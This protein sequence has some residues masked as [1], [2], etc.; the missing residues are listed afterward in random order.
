M[1]ASQLI[2]SDKIE[3]QSH[4]L[5]L[6]T[7]IVKDAAYKNNFILIL[8][9]SYIVA[10]IVCILLLILPITA[11]HLMKELYFLIHEIFLQSISLINKNITT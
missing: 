11:L 10:L 6:L 9:N 1:P 3:M 8:S 5:R 4:H 7:Y 2:L